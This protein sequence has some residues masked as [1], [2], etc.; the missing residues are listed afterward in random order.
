[1]FQGNRLEKAIVQ[2]ELTG[3]F[4]TARSAPHGMKNRS[5]IDSIVINRVVPD[6]IMAAFSPGEAPEKMFSGIVLYR[7][8]C[9][10]R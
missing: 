4:T 2:G 6:R 8:L 1:M 7:I 10:M 9:I 5:Y 3:Q